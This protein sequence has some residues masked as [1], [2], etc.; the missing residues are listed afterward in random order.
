MGM[1]TMRPPV[2]IAAA[3]LALVTA[4]LVA[5]QFRHSEGGEDTGVAA[6]GR[7]AAE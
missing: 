3:V 1:G 2:I 5:R 4:V 7:S 6:A